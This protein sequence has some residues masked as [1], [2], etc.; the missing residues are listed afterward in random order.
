MT[1]YRFPFSEYEDPNG[2]GRISVA[3]SYIYEADTQINRLKAIH[4]VP[5]KVVEIEGELNMRM[6]FS[7]EL[8]AL[9]KYNGFEIEN[10]YGSSDE[11]QF[12]RGSGTQLVVCQM[13]E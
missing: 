2:R 13:M 9:L 7:Q 5:G 8:D 3:G 10:K 11:T 1:T 4:S 6:F 12:D